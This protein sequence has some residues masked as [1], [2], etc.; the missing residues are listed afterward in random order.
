MTRIKFKNRELNLPLQPLSSGGKKTSLLWVQIIANNNSIHFAD[1]TDIILITLYQ[2]QPPALDTITFNY[3]A[4]VLK[5]PSLVEDMMTYFTI[6]NPTFYISHTF[7]L[8]LLKNWLC[9]Y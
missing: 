8:K 9:Y 1:K 7:I 3:E 5:A 6:L 4:K 2:T